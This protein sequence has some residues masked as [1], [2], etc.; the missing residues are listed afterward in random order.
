MQLG[1]PCYTEENANGMHKTKGKKGGWE[2]RRID[3]FKNVAFS[4]RPTIS[5]LGGCRLRHGLLQSG[6]N[7]LQLF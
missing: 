6:H 1:Y 4:A 5:A 7:P 3:L 2:R